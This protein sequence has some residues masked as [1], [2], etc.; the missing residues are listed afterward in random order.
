MYLTIFAVT[1]KGHTLCTTSGPLLVT[2]PQGYISN[3]VARDRFCGSMKAP[4]R[5]E[6]EPGQS[7]NVSLI[8]Y[9]A[10]KNPITTS[11]LAVL[12]TPGDVLYHK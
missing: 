4:W 8:N 10:Q 3:A 12:D 2:Q 9:T 1:S 6:V 7:V 5:I 11:C